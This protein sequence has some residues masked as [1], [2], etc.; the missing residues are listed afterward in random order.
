L[1][2]Y[3]IEIELRDMRFRKQNLL[4]KNLHKQAFSHRRSQFQPKR[5]WRV[6]VYLWN[7]FR[8]NIKVEVI[9]FLSSLRGTLQMSDILAIYERGNT[10]MLLNFYIDL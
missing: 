9:R 3:T 7:A 8:P 5:T 4:G 6:K 1:S 2:P 10:F